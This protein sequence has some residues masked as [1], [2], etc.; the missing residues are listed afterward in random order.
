[1]GSAVTCQR[2]GIVAEVLARLRLAIKSVAK[3]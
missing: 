1:M 3:Y 2:T